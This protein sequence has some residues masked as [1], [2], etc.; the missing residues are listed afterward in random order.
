MTFLADSIEDSPKI[1]TNHIDELKS[2]VMD[3]EPTPA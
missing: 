1:L 2:V 3:F